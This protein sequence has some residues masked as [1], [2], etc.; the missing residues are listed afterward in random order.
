MLKPSS[1]LATDH[2]SCSHEN[3]HLHTESCT[4]VCNELVR[5]CCILVFSIVPRAAGVRYLLE[6]KITL[7]GT[8]G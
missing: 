2:L 6:F 5:C 1:Q 3:I 8:F 7:F 4:S